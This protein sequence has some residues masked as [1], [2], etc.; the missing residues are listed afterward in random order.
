V[1]NFIREYEVTV[2]L[3]IV[4]TIETNGGIKNTR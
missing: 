3:K 1:A 4:N 2:E